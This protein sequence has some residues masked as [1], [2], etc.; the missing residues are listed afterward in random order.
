ML[1]HRFLRIL[2]R[3]LNS[4]NLAVSVLVDFFLSELLLDR[5]TDPKTQ[6]VS[7]LDICANPHA[8][9]YSWRT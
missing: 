7:R 4:R 6:E 8:T 2:E 1:T 3:L 9:F 5:D